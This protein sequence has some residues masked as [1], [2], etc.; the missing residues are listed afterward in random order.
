MMQ[1]SQKR[2]KCSGRRNALNEEG[3]FKGGRRGRE[4]KEIKLGKVRDGTKGVKDNGVT[5]FIKK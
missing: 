3:K 5:V 1:I 2:R 4:R